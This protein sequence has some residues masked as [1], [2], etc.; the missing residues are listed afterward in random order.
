MIPLSPASIRIDAD[1]YD[2]LANPVRQSAY[3]RNSRGYVRIDMSLRQYWHNL[4]DPVPQLLEFSGPDGRAIFLP[5]MA[6]ARE[7]E[8]SLDWSYHLWVYEWLLQSEFRDRLETDLLLK[9][10]ATSAARW[11]GSDRDPDNCGIVIGSSLIGDKAVVGWKFRS[12]ATDFL[13]VEQVEFDEPLPA[14]SGN[15]GFFTTPEFKLDY[16]PGWRPITR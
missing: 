2:D 6:W 16:F 14:P 7:R 12:I 8:L 4:F 9:I 11:T 10:I 5:F 13:E 1:L 3:P 15:F